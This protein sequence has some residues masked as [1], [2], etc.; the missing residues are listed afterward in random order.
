MPFLVQAKVTD[1][2]VHLQALEE[3]QPLFIHDDTALRHTQ[4]PCL[5][6]ALCGANPIIRKVF[7]RRLDMPRGVVRLALLSPGSSLAHP[8]PRSPPLLCTRKGC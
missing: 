6:A 3:N 1:L 4:C 2:S 5:S 7:A 8:F